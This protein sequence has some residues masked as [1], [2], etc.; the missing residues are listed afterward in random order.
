VQ[1]AADEII[2]SR[3]AALGGTGGVIV[4]SRKGEMAWSFNTAGMYRAKMSSESAP[5]IGIFKNEP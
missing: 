5:T 3:L 4:V 2:Q 1:Q